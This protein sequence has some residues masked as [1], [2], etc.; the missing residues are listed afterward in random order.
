M[1]PNIRKRKDNEENS[2][3]LPTKTKNVLGFKDQPSQRNAFTTSSNVI[4]K[5]Q[6]LMSSKQFEDARKVKY[7]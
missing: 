2:P 6:T 4:N 5:K 1:Q 7:L 3:Y